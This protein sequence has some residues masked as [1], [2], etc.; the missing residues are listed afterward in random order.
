LGTQLPATPSGADSLETLAHGVVV[1]VL[2]EEREKC[3]LYYRR[4]RDS[5]QI[6][7]FLDAFREAFV[8]HRRQSLQIRIASDAEI[9]VRDG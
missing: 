9:V 3:S 7:T 8:D 1:R 5:K 2:M 6:V 4:L